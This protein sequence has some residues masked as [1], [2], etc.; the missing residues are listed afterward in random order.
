MI[1][2][3]KHWVLRAVVEA[4]PDIVFQQIVALKQQEVRALGSA[5]HDALTNEEA[6]HTLTLTG[7]WWYQGIHTVH[8]HPQGSQVT[9][10]VNN[11]AHIARTL[12]FLQRPWYVK[13]MRHD[14]EQLLQQI[15]RQIGCPWRLEPA[16]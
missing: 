7:H 5:Y 6:Q 10:K 12:A 13:Q 9:Y 14:F 3:D 4:S 15:G 1:V 8:A 11:I 16:S 2:S